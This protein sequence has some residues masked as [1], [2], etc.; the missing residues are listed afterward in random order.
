MLGGV[1]TGSWLVGHLFSKHAHFRERRAKVVRVVTSSEIA[2]AG[3]FVSQAVELT[4]ANGLVVNLRVLRPAAINGPLPLVV[5][6]GGHRTGRDAIDILGDPGAMVVAALDY[7]YHG[8]ERPRGFVESLRAIP[9]AQRGVLDTPPAV[10]VALDWLCLQPWADASRTELMGV[11]LGVPFATVAG[12]LDRRFR[13]VWLI[14]GGVGN[15]EWIARGLE[16][17]ISNGPVRHSVAALAHLLAYGN[18]FRTEEWVRRIAPRQVVIIGAAS[19][20]QMPRANVEALFAAARQ[21]KEILWSDGGHIQ[22]T[23]SEIVRQLLDM[24][25]RRILEEPDGVGGS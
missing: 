11:S 5:L 13:R 8:P 19:D 3:G 16:R 2:H 10:S 9:A 24:V 1:F 17:R 18:S 23:R 14:H 21:P 12:A 7:P 22:T 4:A 15:R 6:L 20:E 25:R